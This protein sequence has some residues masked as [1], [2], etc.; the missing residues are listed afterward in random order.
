MSSGV[1]KVSG[2]YLVVVSTR[3]LGG[4][5]SKQVRAVQVRTSQVRTGK[6][7]TRQVRSGQVRTVQARTFLSNPSLSLR[8][9]FDKITVSNINLC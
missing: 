3:G 1:C 4:V 7:R 9:V 8:L 5:R 2:W 6:V